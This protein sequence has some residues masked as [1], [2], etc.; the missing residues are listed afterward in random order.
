MPIGL[1]DAAEKGGRICDRAARRHLGEPRRRSV[2]S[3]P[4]RAC[5]S[6][7]AQRDYRTAAKINQRSSTAGIGITKQAHGILPRIAELDAFMTPSRQ[8]RIIEVH[9]EI[10][11]HQLAGGK[12]MRHPKSEKAGLD[13]RRRILQ[14]ALGTRIDLEQLRAVSPR[15]AKDDVLDAIAAAWTAK[16]KAEGLAIGIPEKPPRDRTGLRMEIWA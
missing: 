15:P 7:G 3:P 8:R 13:E 9:P 14:R 2:F 5:L 6:K 12:A 4:V 11:F 10:S 16:R 1:L